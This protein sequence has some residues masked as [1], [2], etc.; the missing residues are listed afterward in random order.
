MKKL[1][2]FFVLLLLFFTQRLAA[3]DAPVSTIS[4]AATYGN[5]EQLTIAVQDFSNIRSLR[6]IIKWDTTVATMAPIGVV[7]DPAVPG[8]FTY[9]VTPGEVVISWFAFPAWPSASSPAYNG[10]IFTLNFNK[11]ANGSTPVYFYT[12][13]PL[14]CNFRDASLSYLNNQP[15]DSFYFDG[16]LTFLSDTD[17]PKATLPTL[18]DLCPGGTID[19]PI[20]VDFF[21]NIDEF[22]LTLN[23]QAQAIAYTTFTNSSGFPNLSVTNPSSGLLNITGNTTNPSGESYP[24]GTTLLTLHFAYNGGY[25]PLN[26]NGAASSY[27]SALTGL[28]LDD[29]PHANFYF[30]GSVQCTTQAPVWQIAPGALDE[31]IPC[32]DLSGLAAALALEPTATAVCGMTVTYDIESDITTPGACNGTYTRVREWSA[33]DECHNFASNYYVQTIT[34]G[35]NTPP[36]QPTAGA[37][38]IQCPADA[39]EPTS[40]PV[41]VDQCG[42]PITPTL[43]SVTHNPDPVTC[44]GTIQ[45]LYTY[46]DCAQNDVTWI[47]TYTVQ[48]TTLPAVPGNGSGNVECLS[49]AVPPSVPTVTDACNRPI[50]PTLLSTVDN[51]DP[52]GCTGT[53][54]YT[55]EYKDCA[56]NTV[57]W[58]YTWH[59]DMSTPPQMPNP[60][61]STVECITDAT[62][63]QLPTF[64]DFCGNTL[65][66]VPL[67]YVDVPD[68][69][70]CNGT[71]TYS[72]L[73]EDCAGNTDTWS[74]T[75]TIQRSTPP[76]EVGGPVPDEQTVECPSL[77]GTPTALPVVEDVC[78]NILVPTGPAIGGTYVDCE[79]TITYTY[80]YTDCANLTWDWVFTWSIIRSTPP[81]E[82]GGPVIATGGAVECLSQVSPPT[83]LPVVH[84]ACGNTLTVSSTDNGGTYNGCE[85]TYTFIYTYT[86]CANLSFDWVYTWEIAR[87][88]PPAEV[89]NVTNTLTVN[90]PGLA[91]EPTNLPVFEGACGETIQPGQP[92]QGGTYVDCEGTITW[93]YRFEDCA[94]LYTDW[95]FTYNIVR[96]G[97]NPPAEVGG[98]VDIASIVACST[99]AV[100]PQLPVVHDECGITLQPSGPTMSGTY[101]DCEGTIIYTYE[102]EDCKQQTFTWVYTYTVQYQ[103]FFANMPADD[104]ST[105]SCP[106]DTDVVPTPPVVYD[107]CGVEI[108]PAGPIA[109]AKPVCEG[110]RT[111]TFTYTDCAQ[112]SH[113]WVYTYNVVYDDFTLPAFAG[114]TVTC[115]DDT[116][117]APTPPTVFDNCGLQ[118][119]PTGPAISTKPSCEGTRTYTWTYTD[120]AQNTHDWVYTYTVVYDDF[121]LP[122]FAGSI[123]TCP[124]DTDVVPTPPTV[125]DN[126]NEV[127]VP[128]GPGISAKP[129]CEGTRTYTWT[130]T[131]CAQ[132]SH[133][134]VYT[135]TVVYDV[136][137]SPPASV[138]STVACLSLA[139]DPG[140]PADIMDACG[141]TVSAALVGSVMN[142]DPLTCEGAVTWTYRYTACDNTTTADWTYTY[143]VELLTPPVVPADGSAAIQCVAD[144]VPPQ[145]PAVTDACNNTL[146]AV[147]VG[148]VDDPTPVTCTGTRTY[149]YSYTD[150][151]QNTSYWEFVYLIQNTTPPVVPADGYASVQCLSLAVNPTPPNVDDVCGQ[152]VTPVLE[153]VTDNP[154][155][156][157]CQGTRTYT[158]SY[159]DCAQNTS[160]W[161][162]VYDI[163]LTIPPVL[164]P[165]GNATVQCI[166]DAVAP[167]YPTVMDH[168]GNTVTVALYSVTDA[169]DPL[170]CEGTRTYTYSYTDCANN[171]SYWSFVYTIDLTTAPVTPA[172][173]GAI[174]PLVSL[175]VPPVTPLVTDACGN[176]TT[177]VLHAVIDSPDPLTTTGTREYIYHFID[178]AQNT[179]VW[180]FTYVI[181]PAT[182]PVFPADQN[183]SVE[184]PDDATMPVPPVYIDVCSQVVTPVYLGVVDS[185]S[186]ILCVGTRTYSWL[187]TDC[188]N[189][190]YT[191]NFTYHIEPTIAPTVPANGSA[192]VQCL[193][194]AVA[195]V[196][197]TVTDQCGRAITPVL[198]TVV[199]VP[200]PLTCEGSRIYT[201]EYTDCNN[202]SSLWQFTYHINRVDPPVFTSIPASSGSTVNCH[203]DAIPP[204]VL[205]NVIDACFATITPSAPVVSGTYNGCE[206]TVVYTYT[207]SDCI[208]QNLSWEYTYTVVMTDPPAVPADG[209]AT[210]ECLG[211]AVPPTVPVVTDQCGNVIVPVLES[212][213]Q[214]P[215]PLLCEGVV[216]YT[217]SF[218][219]CAQNTSTW[220]FTYTIDLTTPPQVPANDSSTVVAV[221]QA[222]TPTIPVVTD[223]CGNSLTAILVSVID[224]PDPIGLTG[225]RTYTYLFEDCAS[226][227]A[228]WQYVYTIDPGMIPPFPADGSLTVE[229][230]DDAVMPVPPSYTDACNNLVTP[231]YVGM[232]QVPDPVTCTGWIEY[233]FEYTDCLNQTHTWRFTY[234]ISPVT[235]PVVPADVTVAV[236]CI[237]DA[238]PP[239]VPVVNDVCGNPLSAVLSAVIDSP[240]PLLCNGTRTYQYTWTDCNNNTSTWNYVYTINRATA[241][242]VD[243]PA[244]TNTANA[245]CISHVSA[246]SSLP[247]V[248]DVC[249]NLLVPAGPV[250]GGTYTACSGTRTYT[251]TWEDC[252]GLPLQ[253]TFTWVIGIDSAPAIPID[254]YALVECVSDATAP[255][256]PTVTDQCGNPIAPTLF[257][258]VDSP[259]PLACQ[260]TRTYT[261]SYTDCAFNTVYWSYVYDI[262][263]TSAPVPVSLP[264]VDQANVQCLSLATP[265]DTIPVV[266]DA[267]GTLI[268]PVGPVTGGDSLPC[269]GTVTYTYTW[270]DCAGLAY[271]WTFTYLVDNQTPPV[272]SCVSTQQRTLPTGT[273]L[274]TVL[275]S[276]FDPV[277][278]SGH[279]G[280]AITLTN[281]LNGLPTLAGQQLPQGVTTITWTATDEC[282]NT[283]TCTFDVEITPLTYS[284][285]LDI[286]VFLQGAFD[287]VNGL[288]HDSLRSKGFIP[289][290]EPYSTPDYSAG[291][292]HV[293]GGGGELIADPAS[294]F[295]TTGPNAIVDWVFIELRSHLDSALVVET[296]SA[297]ITR[298]GQIVDVDGVSPLCFANMSHPAYYVAVR[299]RNHLGVM[300][301]NP[302]QLD[303]A[304]IAIDFRY[305]V[306]PEFDFGTTHPNGVNYTGLAQRQ[307]TTTVRAMFAGNANSDHRLKYQGAG[308]DRNVI[309]AQLLNFPAN[310]FNEYNYGFAFGYFSGDTNMDGQLKYLG[311]GNDSNILL[312]N[313]INYT[314]GSTQAY[315]FLIEQLP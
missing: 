310:S 161:S 51:M 264:L 164:P 27:V 222:V 121:T 151:A 189:V 159:T 285:C 234:Y 102:Y 146:T 92:V 66:P 142:P 158:Y 87:S 84:D 259:F 68:P 31:F 300:T 194:A 182:I 298:S 207:W 247:V 175:A 55:Y 210:V 118:I 76:A 305:G 64:A 177:A 93:T 3:Q 134:W 280:G 204:V 41:V 181:D 216:T 137:L 117:V 89:G 206:G 165:D 95:T 218:T 21:N 244:V 19:V 163:Q 198:K 279:C 14:A 180:T 196:P 162:F 221:V 54:V 133:D 197:P 24:N 69:I 200:Q 257:G 294:V 205:P 114:S 295:S 136:P 156:I 140:A 108:I 59:I 157:T 145:T 187:Y 49:Q 270:T 199:N 82:V 213:A 311:P 60:G 272:I 17:A 141:R 53:M 201:Y 215:D 100:P 77:V 186:T 183:A 119:V 63:P 144:A 85:G 179:S 260:G 20:T 112:N 228:T 314:P 306:Q 40:I 223:A 288:M 245:A 309:L 4:S 123:V 261:Y 126:C 26:W 106:D 74:Y 44:E 248:I 115:P 70:T 131:D 135:Y 255:A 90:C 167:A 13:T 48:L 16:T 276:E 173:A 62:V 231:T 239:I 246:P 282:G 128:T 58:T 232:V 217:Y 109:S 105:V 281:S 103:D 315:D 104:G 46:T 233:A 297:L 166:H 143:L 174:V 7:K 169:P 155:Q 235:L 149:T 265:P 34:V 274:Y 15:P 225:T 266:E 267:C 202:N 32:D 286:H 25:S 29:Q 184:C 212:V 195:P 81:V 301:A 78:G 113:D 262:Q 312:N 71:R 116:D 52:N 153:S 138:T 72:W 22:D 12:P 23:F 50:T 10:N 303:T 35:I 130:Y 18:T 42:N 45:Y 99:D 230:P 125:Y 57:N 243:V 67:G 28:T 65:T 172:N 258:V 47:Y 209:F 226:N 269:N 290:A 150:C 154:S 1:F 236:E 227:T 263:R 176:S 190:D 96:D 168:C 271:S 83:T 275:G 313:L 79:G 237:D 251:Y 191:W 148:I 170:T 6:Y 33:R 30:N 307:V 127:I 252:A 43:T 185:P 253:W 5:S 38:T 278:A 178:C 296:R 132:N 219:D 214:Q 94:G 152:Q 284:G 256:P 98:P 287:P 171:T 61:V 91:V 293:G 304:G 229:C 75:Y 224:N 122:A 240:D 147:L 250:V 291:F 111:Y 110:T 124:D 9:G 273:P 268:S 86:D 37:S 39:T 11:V 36:A 238:I 88:T 299:H 139:V 302:I 277:A 129:S 289:S 73:V 283:A 188:N 308:S 249:G 8:N 292:T 107:N 254:G 2:T 80:T 97:T 120:C 211:D 101:V 56:D 242:V 193:F 241:P 203:A 220:N 192:V 160:Y 208:G